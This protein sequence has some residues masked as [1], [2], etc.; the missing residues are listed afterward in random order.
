MINGT[1]S[2]HPTESRGTDR[3]T[4]VVSPTSKLAT[5]GYPEKAVIEDSSCVQLRSYVRC[6]KNKDCGKDT[7]FLSC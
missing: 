2:R 7:I 1:K 5:W 6:I 4:G 3:T